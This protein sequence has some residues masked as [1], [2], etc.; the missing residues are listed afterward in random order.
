MAVLWPPLM[1]LQNQINPFRMKFSL[2]N[3]EFSLFFHCFFIFIVFSL[4]LNFHC[5]SAT[6]VIGKAWLFFDHRWWFTESDKSWF[7]NSS[8]EVKSNSQLFVPNEIL[9]E[10]TMDIH[11]YHCFYNH[12]Y[13]LL[14][15][16]SYY[17]MIDM[18]QWI[19]MVYCK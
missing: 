13:S 5:F 18:K 11:C 1:I 6:M 7:C 14:Y 12:E 2:K 16:N 19:F 10:K 15:N 3:N 17:S 8:I 4:F 9:L